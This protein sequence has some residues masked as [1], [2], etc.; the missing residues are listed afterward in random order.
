M[1]DY[2]QEGEEPQGGERIAMKLGINAL[3]WIGELTV[4]RHVARGSFSEL[5]VNI[6]REAGGGLADIADYIERDSTYGYL[7]QYF[8]GHKANRV[9]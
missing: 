3:G 8:Y 6:G 5:V 2:L 4:W 1:F 7:G 9:I